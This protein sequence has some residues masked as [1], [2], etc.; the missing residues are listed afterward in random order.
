MDCYGWSYGGGLAQIYATK[1]SEHVLGLILVTATPGFSV[2]S[3]R[4][5]SM[6]SEKEKNE[7]KEMAARIYKKSK[8]EDWSFEKFNRVYTYNKFLNRGWKLQGYYRPTGYEAA[9][10]ALYVG[11]C[12]KAYC[13]EMNL[14]FDNYDLSGA[15]E[16]CPIPT[17]IFESSNDMNWDEGKPELLLKNHPNAKMIMFDESAH[18]PFADEPDKF[19]ASLEKFVK[20]LALVSEAGLKNGRCTWKLGKENL[21]FR[22]ENLEN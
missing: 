18:C 4:Q 12:D 19:F 5:F 13:E 1:H 15:Y 9:T 22:I 8:E 6:L 17:F 10:M 2:E 11:C 7:R 21:E 20:N 3:N 14:S 16:G